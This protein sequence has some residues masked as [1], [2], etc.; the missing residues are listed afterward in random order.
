MTNEQKLE[1]IKQMKIVP[2]VVFNSVDEVIP[3]MEALIKG[4]L[5]C[6]EIT[7]RTACAAE[8][9]SLACKEFPDAF[10]GAGTVINRNQCEQAIVAGAKFIVSPG[11]S[12]EVADCCA[13]HDMLYLPGIVT[14]TEAMAAIAKGLTTLKFFPA[15][16]YGGLKT[17][18][19]ITAAFPYLHIMPTGGISTDNIL[20][21]LAYDKIIACGGS[22]MMKG[23][24]ADI[25]KA[26]KEAVALVN[27]K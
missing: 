20:E 3:K 7:F 26:T 1:L 22:W 17:I 8:A 27:G 11:F 5:P 12:P 16:N 21:Y 19:A 13:E 23:T 10:I 25:E 9:I 24:P 4:G 18:K 15:S 14:P 2:V 6:A